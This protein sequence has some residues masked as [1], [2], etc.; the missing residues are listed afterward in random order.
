[1]ASEI[2]LLV[3]KDYQYGFAT[4]IE[5]D[6]LPPGLN[7]DVVRAISARK[8]EPEWMLEWRLKAFRR[9]Q[10]MTE[11][12]W[13]NVKYPAID[14]QGISYYSAPKTAKPLGSLD[15]LDP[16]LR[17]TYNKLGIPL[18]EQKML[19]GVAV[20]AVFDSVSVGTTY[21]AELAKHGVIFCSFAEAVR[22]HPDLVKRYLG[23]VV[24]YSDN[25]FAALNSAVLDR[26]S[27]RLNS[28]HGYISYAVFCLKKKKKIAQ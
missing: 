19:A 4:D 9:W 24:P 25:Y 20:D 10:Q 16:K 14:Y 1:M 18:Q 23:S 8:N 21:K 12:H 28:S 27:T 5:A 13:S 2:E 11:P 7:E 17:E 15:E 26:K 6:A 22:E 3:N